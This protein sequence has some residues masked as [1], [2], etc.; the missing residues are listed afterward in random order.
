[1]LKASQKG[2]R[3]WH[4]QFFDLHQRL[5]VEAVEAVEADTGRQEYG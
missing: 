4:G 2:M 1:M 3:L 5:A